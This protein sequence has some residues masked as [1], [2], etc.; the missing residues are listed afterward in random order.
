[1]AT[2]YHGR[3]Q[4]FHAS[5][6]Y[7]AAFMPYRDVI[8]SFAIREPLLLKESERRHSTVTT[9]DS[10]RASSPQQRYVLMRENDIGYHTNLRR[11][12]VM[13]GLACCQKSWR[14]LEEAPARH[15]FIL[16][17]SAASVALQFMPSFQSI[18]R[19]YYHRHSTP[20]SFCFMKE[21]P[22]ERMQ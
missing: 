17:L 18:L 11:A 12:V 10:R 6:R 20:T 8:A 22:L 16:M 13:E 2:P 14:L 4:E 19:L 9:G 7:A 21:L 15:C 1:M 5:W 3:E